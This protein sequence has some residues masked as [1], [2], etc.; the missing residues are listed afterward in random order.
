MG[1]TVIIFGVLIGL[2]VLYV[3]QKDYLAS[4]KEENT[5]SH[6]GIVGEET[7]DVL[8]DTIPTL[9]EAPSPTLPVPD[10]ES[11]MGKTSQ[12][13]S[14][15]LNPNKRYSAELKTTAGDIT[16]TF[17]AQA[18]PV[19]VNNFVSLA[20]KDFYDGTVFHRVIRG[21]MIQGGDP[22]GDGSG[23]PGYK[24]DD[25]PFT[26]EYT[27]GTV[28]MANSGPNTNGSQFF[29]MHADSPSLPKNYV[30]FGTVTKGIE[31]V[32]AI[33][34]AEVTRNWSGENSQPVNPVRILNVA[35]IEE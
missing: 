25:E 17:N 14:L 12:Q 29:I 31:V 21:F 30:I 3:K 27:R 15:E 8:P 4:Q 18:T 1:V 23:G 2:G 19:T 34:E 7:E 11:I 5:E 32:D 22:R 6:L 33:A 26:G 16:I 10:I 20:R 35:I 13:S 24:F 28:A 9:I